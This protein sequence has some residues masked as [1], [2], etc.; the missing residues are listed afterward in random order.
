M[1]TILG[2]IVGALLFAAVPIWFIIV[3]LVD[4]RR[5]KI[6]KR[7]KKLAKANG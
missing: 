2:F 6:R 1:N 7:K 3:E 4:E 5:R